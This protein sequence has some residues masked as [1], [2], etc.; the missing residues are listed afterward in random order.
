[1]TLRFSGQGT[2]QYSEGFSTEPTAHTIGVNA[3]P[4]VNGRFGVTRQGQTLSAWIDRG[5]GPRLAR[6]RDFGSL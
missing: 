3:D 4:T 1:M 5:A 6:F 2:A